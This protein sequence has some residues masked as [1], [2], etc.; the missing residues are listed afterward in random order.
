MRREKKNLIDFLIVQQIVVCAPKECNKAGQTI[1]VSCCK[2]TAC[3]THSHP[4]MFAAH[5]N[6]LLACWIFFSFLLR[7]IVLMGGG[8]P[9]S[10]SNFSTG[11]TMEKKSERTRFN[12]QQFVMKFKGICMVLFPWQFA[13][14]LNLTPSDGGGGAKLKSLHK[15][16]PAALRCVCA[17]LDRREVAEIK[18]A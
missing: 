2:T 17:M 13:R 4:K 16:S 10:K 14:Q 12:L 6:F 9:A 15:F 7:Q 8:F 1:K 5:K 18:T 11:K 3:A